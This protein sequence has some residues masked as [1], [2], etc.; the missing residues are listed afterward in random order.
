MTI[1]SEAGDLR[2]CEACSGKGVFL[3]PFGVL[4][5][6]EFDCP[7]CSGTGREKV[8]HVAPVAEQCFRDRLKLSVNFSEATA[9]YLDQLGAK[10]GDRDI[11]QLAARLRARAAE[12]RNAVA[13]G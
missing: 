4:V 13:N 5:G 9:D 11:R 12:D 7:A 2:V 6:V 10:Y 3:D 8:R 1:P